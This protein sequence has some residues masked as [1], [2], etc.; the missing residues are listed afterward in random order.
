M[1]NILIL[2][3]V[4]VI[5]SCASRPGA[6]A[7]ANVSSSEYAGLECQQ[8]R[9]LLA[10]K[11]IDLAES[12]RQQSRAATGDAVGVFLLL[13]PV[14]SLVG[15][16]NEGAVAQNKGEVIALERALVSNCK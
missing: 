9:D 6:I 14:G 8:A 11:R 4:V 10:S 2:L 12:E 3:S 1:K 16:D 7:P 5:S 13:L 15:S